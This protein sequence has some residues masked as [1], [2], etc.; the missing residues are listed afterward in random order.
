MRG[1]DLRQDSFD[2]LALTRLSENENLV[3]DR[4]RPLVRLP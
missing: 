2:D 1:V 3:P 4:P